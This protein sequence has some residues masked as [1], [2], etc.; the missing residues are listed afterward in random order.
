MASSATIKEDLKLPCKEEI[1]R[2][3]QENAPK[4]LFGEHELNL[5]LTQTDELF[6][7]KAK[8]ELR[9]TPEIIAESCAELKKLVEGRT[10]SII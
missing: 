2:Q 1:Y 6:I 8:E 3:W 4:I 5:E 10:R 9:E 7:Q